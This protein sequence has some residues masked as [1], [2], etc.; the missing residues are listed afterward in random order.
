MNGMSYGMNFEA[1]SN[2]RKQHV[3][4][5]A[6]APKFTCIYHA[7]VISYCKQGDEKGQSRQSGVVWFLGKTVATSARDMKRIE[8]R[9]YCC[10]FEV[11]IFLI[12]IPFL[13]I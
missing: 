11:P 3:K 10:L 12:Q 1:S 4:L 5:T 6:C 7:S 8:S 13:L 2:H 9:H